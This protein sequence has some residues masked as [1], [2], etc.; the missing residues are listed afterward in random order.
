[1]ALQDR[2]VRQARGIALACSILLASA[3]VR[4][5]HAEPAPQ[6]VPAQQAGSTL[7]TERAANTHPLPAGYAVETDG[8]VRWTFPLAAAD[9]VRALRTSQARTWRRVV[10]ELGVSLPS[11]LDIRVAVAPEQMRALVAPYTPLPGYADGIAFPEAGLIL[12]TLT[13]PETFL[14]P[15]MQAVLTH[16]LSHVA[17]FRAVRGAALPRWFSEGVAV[18]QARESSFNRT[19]TL[20]EGTLRGG[21]LS[22][23][24]LSNAFPVRH[25]DIDLAYAES[26]DFVGFMMSGGDERSRFRSLLR[27]LAQGGAFP[28]AIQTAYHVP[29]G[30]MEREWRATLTQR[31]GRWPVLFMGLTSIWVLGAVLLVVGYARARARHRSTLQR[32]A[33]EEAPVASPAVS[34]PPPPPAAPAGAVQSSLDDFF[35]N[36]RTKHDPGVPTVVHDGRS[37]TLH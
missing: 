34:A 9:E 35:D 10:A 16:E 25:S 31:F 4:T 6:V 20:W 23:D 29:L 32:W 7:N 11:N 3:V 21:L 27:E 30:Y 12:L 36:R 15:D 28:D 17:L 13:E 22:L 5:A 1:M 24:A 2:L 33:I 19:R 14:R 26:A 37:H 18:Q 8:A